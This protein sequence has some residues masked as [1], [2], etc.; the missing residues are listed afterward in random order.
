MHAKWDLAR[1]AATISHRSEGLKI[2]QKSTFL[3]NLSFFE[4]FVC[5]GQT[6]RGD[7]HREEEE[8]SNLVRV[9][10]ELSAPLTQ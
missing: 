9:E 5:V 6:V 10:K 2:L 1:V 4:V 8:G 3:K 7:S